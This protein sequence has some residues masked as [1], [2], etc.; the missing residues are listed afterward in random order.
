[1]FK[2]LRERRVALTSTTGELFRG[3]VTGYGFR[4]VRLAAVEIAHGQ[5]FEATGASMRFP[6]R[7]IAYLQE[8]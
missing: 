7:Q 3:T 8:L 6:L 1:M 5:E 4:Y 2:G